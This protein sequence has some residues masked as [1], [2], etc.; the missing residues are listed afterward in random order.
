MSILRAFVLLAFLSATAHAACP[1]NVLKYASNS[2][3]STASAYDIPLGTWFGEPVH[4]GYDLAQGLLHEHNYAGLGG[5]CWVR[6]TDLYDVE[7]VAAGTIVPATLELTVSNIEVGT[8]SGCGGTGCWGFVHARLIAGADSVE[9]SAGI[10]VYNV[11][12]VSLPPF[13]VQLG[14]TFTAGTPVALTSWLEGHQTAGGAHET[15]AD[16]TIRFLGLPSG[17]HV[18][19]CQGYVDPSVPALPSSWGA[20]KAAYR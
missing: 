12:K 19:S 7:G 1:A 20:L 17:V 13:K 2:T 6:A 9:Q 18:T 5:A 3:E 10:N 4:L 11:G 8:E 15:D 14:V 16:G